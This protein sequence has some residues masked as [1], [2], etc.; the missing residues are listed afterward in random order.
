MSLCA[1]LDEMRYEIE[2]QGPC[3]KA[4][5]LGLFTVPELA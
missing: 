2:T 1:L 5:T 3:L 4:R